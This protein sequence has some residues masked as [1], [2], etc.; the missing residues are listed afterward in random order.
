MNRTRREGSILSAYTGYLLCDFEDFHKYLCEIL[1]RDV[2]THELAKEEIIAEIKE[3]SE[4]DV[5]SLL[6]NLTD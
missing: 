5:I 4:K 3:K 6:E 1:G 2:W